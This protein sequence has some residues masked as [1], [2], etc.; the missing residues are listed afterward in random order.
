[1]NR[2]HNHSYNVAVVTGFNNEIYFAN[3][4]HPGSWHDSRIIKDS[5]LWQYFEQENKRPF[6][7]AIILGDS[8]YPLTDWMI[9]PYRGDHDKE[10]PKGKFNKRLYM[11]RESNSPIYWMS[12]LI[13]CGL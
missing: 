11:L 2:H 1:M 3:V 4:N 5:K 9:P 12:I 13:N 8:A 10:T 7:G 6:D